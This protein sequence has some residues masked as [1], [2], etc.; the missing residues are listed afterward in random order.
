MLFQ[1]Y[2]IVIVVMLALLADHDV[3]GLLVGINIDPANPGGNPSAAT[4]NTTGAGGCLLLIAIII[5]I[6][7]NNN[8]SQTFYSVLL[9]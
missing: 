2:K 7:S 6:I 1:I 8:Q 3:A 9:L 5:F 4:I